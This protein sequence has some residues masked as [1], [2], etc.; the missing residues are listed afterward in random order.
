MK[1][2]LIFSHHWPAPSP[3]PQHRFRRKFFLVAATLAFTHRPITL[4]WTCI[5]LNSGALYMHGRRAPFLSYDALARQCTH[6]DK[7]LS[8]NDQ[9]E[10]AE[11]SLSILLLLLG[12]EQ[13]QSPEAGIYVAM[14]ITLSAAFGGALALIAKEHR[15]EQEVIKKAE[16]LPTFAYFEGGECALD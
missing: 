7:K 9:F 8:S 3:S 13:T 14:I 11:L 6:R 12:I 15:A 10:M 2:V 5:V 4:A 16:Q 1:P